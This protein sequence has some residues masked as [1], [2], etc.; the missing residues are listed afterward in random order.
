ML[1]GIH[2]ETHRAK[3]APD[4]KNTVEIRDESI[5]RC[6]WSPSGTHIAAVSGEGRLRLW[7]YRSGKL[8]DAQGMPKRRGVA[9]L[10]W[11]PSGNALAALF[12]SYGIC[13]WK[14]PYFKLKQ[15]LELGGAGNASAI[16]WS[17][18]EDALLLGTTGGHVQWHQLGSDAY[19]AWPG[20]TAG[21]SGIS[22]APSGALAASSS[23]DRTIR[24]WDL[25]NH[26]TSRIIEGAGADLSSLQWS[27]NPLVFAG[28]DHSGSVWLWNAKGGRGARIGEYPTESRVP[29][30]IQPVAS[31]PQPAASK[32]F[33]IHDERLQ[34]ILRN[35][36]SRL[37]F[38]NL[39]IHN[40]AW[41]SSGAGQLQSCA[42]SF[43]G[44]RSMIAI[45]TRTG[46]IS[47][48]HSESIRRVSEWTEPLL[49]YQNAKVVLVGDTGVGKSGLSLVLT[50]KN[51][52]ATESTH[53]RKVLELWR[54]E[55]RIG[56][57]KVLREI[58]LWD[59]A[60]Q[61]GYRLIHQLHLHETTVAIVAFDAR[62][63]TD[64]LSGIRYWD[65]ALR[66]AQTVRGAESLSIAKLLAGTRS[67]RGGTGVSRPR[68]ER[69]V[70]ELGYTG[71]FS[72]SA[73]TGEGIEELKQKV[74]ELV[75]WD[76]LPKVSSTGFFREVREFIVSLKDTA[77]LLSRE[78]LWKRF[79]NHHSL[80]A[81]GPV[82][83][84]FQAAIDRLA[85][86][87]LIH[88]FRFGG[89]VLLQPE[90]LDAYASALVLAA[91]SEPDGMGHLLEDTVLSGSF[92]LSAEERLTDKA[93]EKLLIIAMLEDLLRH[94]IALRS[95]S[96]DGMLLVF[97]SQLTRDFPEAPDPPGKHATFSFAGSVQN[98]YA[99][100][101]VRMAHTSLFVRKDLWRNAATFSGANGGECGFWMRLLDEGR[102]ELLTFATPET[103]AETIQNFERFVSRHLESRSVPGSVR[104]SAVRRCKSCQT[105]FSTL[106]IENRQ[107]RGFQ[108][109][110]CSVCDVEQGIAEEK[111]P[112]AADK[113][114]DVVVMTEAANRGREKQA[115]TA[116]IKGKRATEDFDVFL[117]HNSKEKDEVRRMAQAL[118]DRGILPWIDEADLRPG[119][120][121]LKKI[122]QY[123]KKVPAALICM[124]PAGPGPWMDLEFAVAMTLM[125]KAGL[126]VIPVVILPGVRD[127]DW[128]SFVSILHK[129]DMAKDFDRGMQQVVFGIKGSADWQHPDL[130][131]AG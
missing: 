59:M 97:P 110:R 44:S 102:A 12:P 55:E 5:V 35:L 77:F 49:Q 83:L 68:I 64:P 106:Q 84:E 14:L 23:H 33:E 86:T 95:E 10:S 107:G 50:G 73:K 72:T 3:W 60:G 119:D 123:L 125:V 126:R 113:S 131:Q 54:K 57:E 91:Q 99:T 87:D 43:S 129:V 13:V 69:L 45:G 26:T 75:S 130:L 120:V 76:A 7:E 101:V 2:L 65:R 9:E 6:L 29:V 25:T 11:S 93:Q 4:G 94:E 116:I 103:S 108:T 51:F 67:D 53:G 37:N 111:L 40:S 20:H 27:S 105:P 70:Q 47:L 98:S 41:D 85:A 19:D 16:A 48:V 28:C 74:L 36:D 92:A 8:V 38:R 89:L 21:I 39:F 22:I 61:P 100:L 58:L 32:D 78:E 71:F 127:G 118:Q 114:E 82:Q 1:E 104:R 66:Q 90:V 88:P 96:E 121:W 15:L 124:G 117:V 62:N 30:S 17:P 128:N 46:A 34:V 81:D 109:I 31:N 80:E 24:V 79:A 18:G 115:A 122:E 42:F 56:K 63:E 52:E 112:D